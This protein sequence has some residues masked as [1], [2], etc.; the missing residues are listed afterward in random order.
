MEFSGW[1][2]YSS[3]TVI[4]QQRALL[5]LHSGYENVNSSSLRT[6]S[7]VD[8]SDRNLWKGTL[9]LPW[10]DFSSWLSLVETGKFYIDI[11]WFYFLACILFSSSQKSL[12]LLHQILIQVNSNRNKFLILILSVKLNW[13]LFFVLSLQGIHLCISSHKNPPY[14]NLGCKF[15]GN[16]V[17]FITSP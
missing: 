12:V 5:I 11:D 14:I 1:Y 4:S 6:R 2:G 10:D 3:I 17:W 13:I 7:Q 15:P 9:R 8:D 16:M